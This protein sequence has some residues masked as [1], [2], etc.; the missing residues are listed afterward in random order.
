V[1]GR[2]VAVVGAA[3]QGGRFMLESMVPMS[4]HRGARCIPVLL[5]YEVVGDIALYWGEGGDL[6]D[7][8][9]ETR[10]VET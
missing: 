10:Q 7:K 2:S 8:N 6:L 1:N 5:V 4:P 9:D 3:V